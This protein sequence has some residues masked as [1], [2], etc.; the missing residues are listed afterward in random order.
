LIC[1]HQWVRIYF[2]RQFFSFTHTHFFVV[3]HD[4]FLSDGT[5]LRAPP[6]SYCGIFSFYFYFDKYFLQMVRH[7][8]DLFSFMFYF[9]DHCMTLTF[10]HLLRPTSLWMT[11][12][13]ESTNLLFVWFSATLFPQ[14]H[15]D[16]QVFCF[17]FSMYVAFELNQLEMTIAF[18]FLYFVFKLVI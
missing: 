16:M 4:Y 10:F 14:N 1:H 17:L 3:D 2:N 12:A 13:A 7:H 18:S 6:T 11:P 15:V 5:R 8:R 9:L